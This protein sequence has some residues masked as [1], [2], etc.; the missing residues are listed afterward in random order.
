MG[1][2][3]VAVGTSRAIA[4]RGSDARRDVESSPTAF[5]S[6]SASLVRQSKFL[7]SLTNFD[8]CILRFPNSLGCEELMSS[9]LLLMVPL[10]AAYL[11]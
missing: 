10:F 7:K 6:S 8:W 1:G 3:L 9:Y 5:A 2:A 4:L 11:L